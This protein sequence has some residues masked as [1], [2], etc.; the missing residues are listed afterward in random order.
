L[1]ISKTL[2][3]I[4]ER[5]WKLLITL[6]VMHSCEGAS[7]IEDRYYRV[8]FKF[9][10]VLFQIA[11]SEELISLSLLGLDYYQNYY[12]RLLL[13]CIT[14]AFLGWITWLLQSLVGDMNI[15]RKNSSLFDVQHDEVLQDRK[16]STSTCSR[17]CA[18]GY[19]VN[20]AFMFLVILTVTLIFCK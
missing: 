5:A 8:V 14:L 12:Q 9:V 4:H 13:S 11:I 7:P 18:G 6:I 19:C 17:I 16:M 15:H 20:I 2:D 3:L 10:F 1:L